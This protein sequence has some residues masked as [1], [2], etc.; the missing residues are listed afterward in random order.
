[1]PCRVGITTNL[2]RRKKEWKAIHPTLKNWQKL[3]YPYDTKETA[4]AAENL[5]AAMHGCESGSGG[6][7]PDDPNAKWYVYK[8][9]Y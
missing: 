3:G 6:D 8:F 1:M 2:E 7:D 4:Q 5:A 9:D